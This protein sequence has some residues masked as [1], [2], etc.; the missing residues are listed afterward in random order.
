MKIERVFTED[1]KRTVED[2]FKEF[3]SN[4][5]NNLVQDYKEGIH[6]KKEQTNDL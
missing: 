6:N 3:I 1:S 5:I 4:Q 2:L